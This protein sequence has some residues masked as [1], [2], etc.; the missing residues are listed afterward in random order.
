MNGRSVTHDSFSIERGYDVSPARGFAAWADPQAKARW[1]A[2]PAEWARVAH[3]LDFRV[4]AASEAPEGRR[5]AR[6]TLH[7]RLLG[8]RRERADRQ[9]L[10]DGARRHPDLGVPHDG[11]APPGRRRHA[12]APHRARRPPRRARTGRR[13]G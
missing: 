6:S 8:H 4:G 2:G 1:F 13:A 5:A 9:H 11:R 10:R 3:E 12:A 7:R